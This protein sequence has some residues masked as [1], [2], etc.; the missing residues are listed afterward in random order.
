MGH[1]V[2]DPVEPHPN[3]KVPQGTVKLRR[4]RP[5][6][7][8]NLLEFRPGINDFE[9]VEGGENVTKQLNLTVPIE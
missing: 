3:R 2:D 9:V 1:L 8:Q 4:I 6:W 7:E 5:S